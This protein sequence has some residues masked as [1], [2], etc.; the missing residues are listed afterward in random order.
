MTVLKRLSS[1]ASRSFA[2]ES[3]GSGRRDDAPR[4]GL[5]A[6][7]NV[8]LGGGRL[9]EVAVELVDE[10]VAVLCREEEGNDESRDAQ[11]SPVTMIST[12][13]DPT[14]A[15]VAGGD[16]KRPLSMRRREGAT[17]AELRVVAPETKW[18]CL[19]SAAQRW[20]KRSVR[21]AVS[22][23]ESGARRQG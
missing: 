18:S 9:A 12:F 13:C 14:R 10:D 21:E 6:V 20:H 15:A 7:E 22:A 1:R 2:G 17:P 23:R 5:V 19:E 4:A 11:P 16:S 3:R 8:L